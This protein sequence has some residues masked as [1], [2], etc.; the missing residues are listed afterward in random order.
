MKKKMVSIALVAVMCFMFSVPA[1]AASETEPAT[2]SGYSYWYTT[3]GNADVDAAIGSVG[4]T[5]ALSGAGPIGV[6]VS[7]LIAGATEFVSPREI[8][9]TYTD[10]V[11][12]CDN[13]QDIPYSYFHKI[14]YTAKFD[15]DGDGI[16]ESYTRWTSYYEDAVMPRS[17]GSGL[18]ER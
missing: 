15:A 18:F 2:P 10:K 9:G 8:T 3:T 4:L 7:I 16:K 14:K 1:F 13:P 12:K 11:Y 17:V 6:G 5:I